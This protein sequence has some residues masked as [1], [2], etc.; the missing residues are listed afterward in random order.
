[1]N[2]LI[3]C[4]KCKKK[5]NNL[6]T[7]TAQT[8]NGHWR[9]SAQCLSAKQTKVNLYRRIKCCWPRNYTNL[10]EYIKKKDPFLLKELMIYGLLV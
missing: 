6:N 2:G 4:S 8:S 3:Y 7:I 1:M 10:S 5:T 9:A